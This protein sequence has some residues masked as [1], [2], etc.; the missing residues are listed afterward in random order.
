MTKRVA[1][2]SGRA[3]PFPL[4]LPIRYRE[5]QSA[6]WFE[7]ETENISWSGILIR[8]ERLLRPNTP[9]EMRL[10]LPVARMDRAPGEIVCKGVIVRTEPSNIMGIP[11]ALGVAIRHYRF[12]RT[13]QPN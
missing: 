11:P 10:T 12:T 3:K 8:T 13:R 7:G 9:V 6:G 1:G 5:P 4:H 2:A